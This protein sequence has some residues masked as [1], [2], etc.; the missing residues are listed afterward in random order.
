MIAAAPVVAVALVASFVSS[1]V[2]AGAVGPDAWHVE[3]SAAFARPAA[4]V[5]KP[6][7]G[8]IHHTVRHV[9]RKPARVPLSSARAYARSRLSATQFACL[10]RLW[11]RESNWN[12][13]SLNRSSGAYGIPQAVPGSRMA[14]AGADWRTNPITQVRWGLSYIKSRYGTPCAALA[15]SN[16]FNWY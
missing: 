7:P 9:A 13:R 15:H 3:A 6:K 2:G 12:P 4:H 16:R 1:G 8:P 10:D 5:A 14:A 11:I